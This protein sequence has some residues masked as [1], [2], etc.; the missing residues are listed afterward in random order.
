MGPR[1]GQLGAGPARHSPDRRAAGSSA[2]QLRGAAAR[3]RQAPQRRT[4]TRKRGCRLMSRRRR[5]P[6][7]CPR[8]R[9]RRRSH[10]R[11]HGMGREGGGVDVCKRRSQRLVHWC[12]MQALCAVRRTASLPACAAIPAC[13]LEEGPA[14]EHSSHLATAMGSFPQRSPEPP[15]PP[16]AL[17]PAAGWAAASRSAERR[18]GGKRRQ[19]VVLNSHASPPAPPSPASPPSPPTAK[20]PYQAS[21]KRPRRLRRHRRRL[22]RRLGR[23]QEKE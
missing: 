16:V 19:V 3:G 8:I 1:A 15:S 22:R 21:Q 4:L 6:R 13:K 7:R 12:D 5:P 10:C 2:G 20:S 11:L 17:G 18:A 23:Q 14:G 9:P